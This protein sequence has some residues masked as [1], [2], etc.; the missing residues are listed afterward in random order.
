MGLLPKAALSSVVGAATRL[1]APRAV[2]QAAMRAF[3]RSYDV[4][5]AEAE[6]P[7]EGYATFSEF[8]SRRLKEGAR[9]LCSA[10]RAIISP[11]DGA[12][13]Q[14]GVLQ[15][16]LCLQAKGISFPVE[17]LLANPTQA[18]RFVNGAYATLY[19]AP[20][21]YH[22]IHAPLAGAILGCEYLPGEFWPV[23]RASVAH[24]EALFCLN[25]RLVTYLETAAGICAVVMVGATCVS[26]IRASFDDLVTHSGGSTEVRDYHPPKPIARGAELGLFEMGSTVILLFEPGKIRWNAELTPDAVVRMGQPLGELA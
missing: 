3:A 23:N 5:L 7:L 1:P 26:R 12:V 18:E 10:E 25:E 21:D 19:L 8:F 16:G 2:H 24:K 14:A 15:A 17:K 6:L 4:N 11:V 9:T 22:R 13:S 20:R